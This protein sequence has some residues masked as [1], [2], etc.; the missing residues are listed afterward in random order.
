[1]KY[2]IDIMVY[3]YCTCDFTGFNELTGN[4]KHKGHLLVKSDHIATQRN[5]FVIP[6]NIY[7]FTIEHNRYS[8]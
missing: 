3:N 8:Q 5:N 4:C 6:C 1:M 7:I 2:V